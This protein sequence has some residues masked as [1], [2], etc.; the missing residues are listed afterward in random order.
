MKMPP[1][2][3][4]VVGCGVLLLLASAPLRAQA[5]AATAQSSPTPAPSPSPEPAAVATTDATTGIARLSETVVVT[6]S[7]TEQLLFDSPVAISVLGPRQ[8]ETTPA[9]NYGDLLRGVPGV[10]VIQTSARDV[11]IRA[12][13]AT[14]VTENSQLVLLDGRSIYLDFY[15][16]VLWDY[17]PLD[18]D[19][20]KDIEVARGPGSAVW[21]ANAL[22][23]VINLRTKPPREIEGGLV[24]LGGGELGTR[25]VSGRYARAFEKLSYKAGASYYRQDQWQRRKTLPNGDPLPAGY[26]FANLGTRQPKGDLRVDYDPEPGTAWSFRAGIGGTSGIVHTTIG[27]FGI[28]QGAHVSYAEAS[29]SHGG[30]E[31]KAY[32][33]GL[34]GDAPNLINGLDFTFIN[35]T[36][37]LDLTARHLFGTR[38]VLVTGGNLRA[39]RFD[40]NL[41]PNENARNDA[42]VFAE[43]LF[44][45]APKVSLT[46]GGRLDYFDTLGATFSPRTSVLFKPTAK[47]QLRLAYNRAYR[48]PSLLENFLDTPVPNVIPLGTTPFLFISRALGNPDLREEY[49][50]SVEVGWTAELGARAIATVSAYQNE[51]SENIA[52]VPTA[53]FGPENPPPGWPLP[54]FTVPPFTLPETFGFVNVGRVRD[55]GLET[56]LDMDVA[57]GVTVRASYTLQAPP[58]ITNDSLIPLTLNKPPRHQAGL[59]IAW[60]RPRFFGSAGITATSPAFWADVLDSRFWGATPGYALVNAALG[61]RFPRQKAEVALNATNLFDRAVQQHIFGD[62]IRRKVTA[63]VR[64]KF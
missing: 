39:N 60:Q 56:S 43:D 48:S 1:A 21:G 64:V 11:S 51:I 25:S 49:V 6:A 12:R 34:R 30:L 10:N 29:Y 38:H 44:T 55:R 52:F 14:G 9:D 26:D 62:I 63:Q 54:P 17:I 13:G 58:R 3:R 35:D 23:G 16:V 47:Q 57:A 28:K 41:A 46:F 7:R 40:I 24:S 42:G 31:A 4:A 45:L 33:N 50:H 22:S 15:G 5:P 20:I 53:F 19:E 2:L 59:S 61:W 36:Y 37:V 32:W 8:I 18:F 27:P